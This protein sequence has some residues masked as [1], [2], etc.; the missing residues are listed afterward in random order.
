MQAVQITNTQQLVNSQL[1]A[2]LL[3]NKAYNESETKKAE[4]SRLNDKHYNECVVRRGLNP[5]W[6][7][8]NVRSMNTREAS[9]RLGYSAKSEGIWLEGT[10]G[11]GQFRPNKPW[12]NEGDKKAPKYR[13]ATGEEYD[14]MLPKHPTN[15]QYWTDYVALQELAWQINGH[16]CLLVTEGMFKAICA[17]SNDIPCIA[18]AGVEQGL[19]SVK[20]DLQGKRYLVDTLELLARKGFGFIIVFDADAATN[21]NVNVAQ[22]KLAVQLAKFKVPIYIGT[23]LWSVEEGKG[24]DDYIQKNGADKFK[25][26]VLGK[27][28]DL[29]TWERQFKNNNNDENPITQKTFVNQFASDHRARMAWNVQTQSWYWY[30]S[31]KRAGIWGAIPNEE[32]MDIV[33]TQLDAI[34]YDYS[35]NFV[36]ACLTLLKAKLRVN[37][38][39]VCKNLICL[40]DCV[41]DVN[42]LEVKQHEPGYRFLSRLPFKWS[43]REIGCEPIKQWLLETCGNRA[44]WVEVLRAAMNATLTERGGEYQRYMELLGAG[45]TG[46]GTTLR[47]IQALLGKENYAVTTLKQLESNQFE[48]AMFYGKKAIF[49]TDS[50]RFTKEVSTLKALTGEDELRIEKKRVQ[51]TGSFIFPGVV[52]VAANEPM[53]SSDYTNGLARRRLSMSFERV[54][55]PHLRRNL[56]E[57]FKAYLPGLLHWVLSMPTDQVADFFRNT[58]KRVLSLGSFSVEVLLDTNPLANWA[59]QNLCYDPQ[60]KT[61]IGD[62]RGNVEY[63]LFA[64]YAEWASANR[65]GDGMSVQR[66]SSNL[67]NL[68]KTQLNIDAAKVRT[69]TGRYITHIRIRQPGDNSPLLFGD[70]LMSA[71]ADSM[72]DKVTAETIGSAD[73]QENAGKLVDPI[74]ETAST[75][76]SSEASK[77]TTETGT[78]Q[79]NGSTSASARVA[80]QHQSDTVTASNSVQVSTKAQNNNGSTGIK[81]PETLGSADTQTDL[82]FNQQ[83][84]TAWNSK[85]ELGK[86]ILQYAD[87]DELR[88]LIAQCNP[89]QVKIIKSAASL[90]WRPGCNSFGEYRG[91]KCEL[92][93]FGTTKRTWK[94]HPVSGKEI[95]SVSVYDVAPWLGI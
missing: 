35:C 9:E 65:Q 31:K 79:Q 88:S 69:K 87:T 11:F 55:P 14:A 20:L 44:D 15:K 93:E 27:V 56:M 5:E 37:E 86:L 12:K 17:C 33:T 4:T 22:H 48:T 50:E 73:T 25:R 45:S 51:Q 74:S 78:S 30:E 10:N 24:M 63:C 94:V 46:K 84:F 54:I 57:E 34:N 29:E 19:T 80:S 77:G 3:E 1:P 90:V 49:I 36:Q 47:L 7:V 41:I 70:D 81:N 82:S 83:V 64:N 8:M 13:T 26:E 89:E 43:D 66:F 6:I 39:E 67:L 28:V 91:E 95:I 60:T 18:L 68:L 62:A 75:N 71:D 85:S 76:G 16:P 59:N 52:W 23:G 42:T 92:M 32:A 40:E 53:Q 61:Q 21:N 72:S 58:S 2:T 38:W